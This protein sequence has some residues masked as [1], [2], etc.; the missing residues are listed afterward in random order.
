MKL[1]VCKLCRD[2]VALRREDRFCGCRSCRGRY[3][4]NGLIADVAG[5][6]IVL[7]ILNWKF[8]ELLDSVPRGNDLGKEIGIFRI[9]E[10]REDSHVRMREFV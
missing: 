4:D 3:Q 8:K 9:N 2:V 10:Q 5:P 6:C 1:L 7:G